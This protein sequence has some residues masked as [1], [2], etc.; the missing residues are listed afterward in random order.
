MLNKRTE[1]SANAGTGTNMFWQ[2]MIAWI[3]TLNVRLNF[4]RLLKFLKLLAV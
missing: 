1:I 4:L 3:E 2:V